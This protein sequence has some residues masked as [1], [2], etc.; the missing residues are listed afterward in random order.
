MNVSAYIHIPFCVRKCLYCDFN[1]YPG[2]EELYG[3]YVEALKA[4]IR[5][6]GERYPDA[7]ISTIYFG[8]GTPNV[9]S[10]DQLAGILGEIR[11][12]FQVADD[13]EISTEANPGVSSLQSTVCGLRSVGFNRLSL[14]VQ[15]FHDDELRLLG[16]IHTV[17]EAVQAFRDA[18]DAGFENVSIDLMYGIPGQT[19]ESWQQTLAQAVALGSEHVSLYS[20]TVEE[21]TP[22][23]SMQVEGRLTLPGDDIEA[24][25]YEDAIRALT[26][27][28]FVHYEISN[29]ARPGFECRH[30]ITYWH[31]EPYFGFGSGA[32]GYIPP[33]LLSGEGPGV[34]V[35]GYAS[36]IT[37]VPS[38]EEYIRRIQSGESPVE[39]EEHLTGRPAMG[40]TMFL[41][42][43][44]LSGVDIEAFAR[45]YGVLPQEVF[46]Q[47]ISELTQ[48]GLIEVSE[49]RLRLTRQGLFLGTDVFVEFVG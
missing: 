42:L 3:S 32:T 29:F 21:G 35:P 39:C 41:G 2:K 34:R 10:A 15:S 6:A 22:F 40:E 44:M 43:R 7:R 5:Q 8:G 13:A 11:Q 48:R 33:R 28:G 20:L 23:H 17:G 18:R 31:N 12:S 27:A 30:N 46:A 36:R 19:P 9:L 1:S 14:G 4:E 25:M 38:V 49:G 45:R 47:E 37:N 24:D 16:R 26:D